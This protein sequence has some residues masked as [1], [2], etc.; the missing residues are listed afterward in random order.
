MLS[1]YSAL[2]EWKKRQDIIELWQNWELF[3]FHRIIDAYSHIDL[4][5]ILFKTDFYTKLSINLNIWDSFWCLKS[6]FLF[7]KESEIQ[8]LFLIQ[9][10]INKGAKNEVVH[11]KLHKCDCLNSGIHLCTTMYVYGNY[12]LGS[13]LHKMNDLI[14]HI[15]RLQTTAPFNNKDF[16]YCR[17]S[18]V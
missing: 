15:R 9:Q 11:I 5:F 12:A 18:L 7:S 2:I 8:K 17:I 14:A 4:Q 1:T 16:Q 13:L 10:N 3:T 6:P